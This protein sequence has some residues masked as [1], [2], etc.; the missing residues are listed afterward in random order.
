MSNYQRGFV[1]L[2]YQKVKDGKSEWQIV[3]DALKISEIH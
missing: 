3:R 2:F 1:F